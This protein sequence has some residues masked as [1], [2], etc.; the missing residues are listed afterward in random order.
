MGNNISNQSDIDTIG[1][2]NTNINNYSPTLTGG[3]T[4]DRDYKKVLNNIPNQSGGAMTD[5]KEVRER[6]NYDMKY[7][8]NSYNTTYDIPLGFYNNINQNGGG[9]DYDISDSSLHF[10]D[11]VSE[12]SSAFLSSNTFE[13][14][15]IGGAKKNKTT[16]PKTKSKPKK[17]SKPK[18][19]TKPKRKTNKQYKSRKNVDTT[20]SPSYEASEVALDT[21]FTFD[22]SSVKSSVDG[23]HMSRAPEGG[24]SPVITTISTSSEISSPGEG[25]DVVSDTLFVP[26][27]SSQ[28]H[29]D[30]DD[31]DYISTPGLDDDD[32]IQRSVDAEFMGISSVNTSDIRLITE[33]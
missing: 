15:M 24:A 14:V 10:N 23:A 4:I 8:E 2:N 18:T 21:S 11:S 19:K 17:V 20:K 30:I 25:S 31:E 7:K 22:S 27:M 26:V 6:L 9:E 32:E 16:K 5:M 1:F 29:S 28:K 3:F 13:K 33:Q 12:G